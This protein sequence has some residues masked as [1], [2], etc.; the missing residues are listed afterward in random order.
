[1]GDRERAI[2]AEGDTWS[3]REE[4]ERDRERKSLRER[5]KNAV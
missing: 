4:R 5:H 1:M 3:L 2:E